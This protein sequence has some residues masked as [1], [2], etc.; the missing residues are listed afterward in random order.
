MTN[1]TDIEALGTRL[2]QKRRQTAE[3]YRELEG[4]L[5]LQLMFPDVFKNGSV[6]LRTFSRPETGEPMLEILNAKSRERL[7][8]AKLL[9]IPLVIR[10]DMGAEIFEKSRYEKHPDW[11][12]IV[13][14]LKKTRRD[15]STTG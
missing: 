6:A 1:N 15:G 5:A 8:T 13:L 12:R 11:R 7:G 14:E 10:Q 2:A 3:L 9:D 4:S